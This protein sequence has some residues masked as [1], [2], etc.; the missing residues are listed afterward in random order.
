MDGRVR[1]RTYDGVGFTGQDTRETGEPVGR[2]TFLYPV[3]SLLPPLRSTRHS[4]VRHKNKK[5]TYNTVVKEGNRGQV[6]RVFGTLNG[7]W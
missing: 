2:G 6:H 5:K 1:W 3:K 4:T 7:W